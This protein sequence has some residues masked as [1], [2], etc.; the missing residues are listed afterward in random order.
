MSVSQVRRA[1]DIVICG[2]KYSS[3]RHTHPIE[4]YRGAG[5]FQVPAAGISGGH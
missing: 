5:M 1:L 3:S 2:H 4:D